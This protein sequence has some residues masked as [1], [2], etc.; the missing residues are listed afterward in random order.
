MPRP[1]GSAVQLDTLPEAL[2]FTFQLE[3]TSA[4]ALGQRCLPILTQPEHQRLAAWAA[5]P[6]H[7]HCHA[8]RCHLTWGKTGFW[9]AKWRNYI[10]AMTIQLSRV[11]SN[12][13]FTY[14]ICVLN[15]DQSILT[16]YRINRMN[17]WCIHITDPKQGMHANVNNVHLS[18]TTVSWCVIY[19]VGLGKIFLFHFTLFLICI[20]IFNNAL[21][22]NLCM[23]GLM[24]CQMWVTP[25]KNFCV[26]KSM[27]ICMY[28][29][30]PLPQTLPQTAAHATRL[31]FI[32]YI[33][34]CSPLPH[35]NAI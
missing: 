12:S 11:K 30:S 33:D 34:M 23:S 35:A 28:L 17:I 4:S 22:V 21:M 9:S 5:P 26:F 3:A 1:Q 18:N 25:Q 15:P 16:F 19:F 2:P 27:Q 7:G 24:I 29:S 20:L 13:L 6:E 10:Q 14:L 31:S 32:G 8:P